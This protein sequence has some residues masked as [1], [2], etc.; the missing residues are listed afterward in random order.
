[1]EKK[2]LLES[3]I[4]P[5]LSTVGKKSKILAL[6]RFAMHHY[7]ITPE[8]FSILAALMENDGMYQSQI[9]ASTMKDRPNITRLTNILENM[10]FVKRKA[11]VN[12]RKVFKIFITE[13]GKRTYNLI[14]PTILEIWKDTIDNIND[15][16]LEITLNVL[17]KI[18]I[19]LD[20]NINIKNNIVRG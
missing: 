15:D 7:P 5:K 11:D 6:Q 3:K 17:Q 13:E 1:M 9:A 4:G 2:N 20:N 18:R 16:E 14:L 8:Q 10:N 19:N 12:K